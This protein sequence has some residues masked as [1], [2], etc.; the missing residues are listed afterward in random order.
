MSAADFSELSE[1]D[2]KRKFE[3]QKAVETGNRDRRRPQ[4]IN[5]RIARAELLD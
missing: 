2:K 4:L 5:P 3:L 1:A